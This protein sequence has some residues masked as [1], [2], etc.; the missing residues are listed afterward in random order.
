M[1]AVVSVLVYAIIIFVIISK[2][3]KKTGADAKSNVGKQVSKIDTPAYKNVDRN[4]DRNV[5]R[6]AYKSNR[7]SGVNK[8]MAR[9]RANIKEWEDRRNDW[10]ARQMD[11]ERQAKKRMSEMFQ[12]K[13][14]HRYNCEAEML[15]QFHESHCDADDVDNAQA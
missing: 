15:K 9:E 14:E 4:V 7:S 8:H 3:K 5:N 12:L 1:D 10:L 2:V 11:D 6:A 13:M